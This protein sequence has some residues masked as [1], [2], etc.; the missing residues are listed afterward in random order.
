V[1]AIHAGIAAGSYYQVNLCF[2]V[3]FEHFGTPRALFARLAQRQP[4]AYCAFLE[5]DDEVVL[6]LSPELFVSRHGDRLCARPMKGTALRGADPLADRRAAEALATSPKDRAENVM[7]VDLLRND[8]GRLAEPGSVR[9]DRLCEVEALPTVWQMTS[10][11]SARARAAGLAEVLRALFPCG[12][13]TGAPKIAAM[14]E[15]ARLERAPRELYTGAVGWLA[16]DGDLRLNVAIRTPE[17]APDGHRGT[18]GVGAGITIDSEPA[19]EYAEC[20][21]KA[22]FLIAG[23]PGLELVETLRIEAGDPPVIARLDAHLTRLAASARAFGFPCDETATR[24]TL[25]RAAEEAP[26]AGP[27]RLRLTLAHDGRLE[28]TVN[29]LAPLPSHL[30]VRVASARLDPT[31]P[32]RR[33]K[34]TAR[35]LYERALT[36]VRTEPAVFDVLFF[37]QRGEL[38]EGARSNVFL[39]TGSRLLTPPLASGCLPGV[40]RAELLARGQAVEQVIDGE[41]LRR[42]DRVWVGNALRGLLPVSVDNVPL[43]IA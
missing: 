14:R 34:T 19:G 41:L 37:N 25:L 12:S 1:A 29:V 33:H 26:G 11:I 30:R 27:W 38:C 20:L 42:A 24:A 22:R 39:S 31:D 43:A 6:S 9:V 10:T 35:D 4:S 16:P 8:L 7:I 18:M 23:D 32:L 17:L 21:A 13:I 5:A 2:A 15:I 40:L 28:V 36:A 3:A